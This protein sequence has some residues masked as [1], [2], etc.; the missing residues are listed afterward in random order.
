MDG[1]T[2]AFE[3]ICS[4]AF[5]LRILFVGGLVGLL[6]SL[7][8]LIAFDPGSELYVISVLNLLGATFVVAFSGGF[9]WK[10]FRN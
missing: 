2:K 6:L 3:Y 9:L 4:A 5:S 1:K 10:C 7:L 8:F